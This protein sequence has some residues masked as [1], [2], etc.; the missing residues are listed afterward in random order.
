MLTHRCPVLFAVT[1]A[2]LL[3]VPATPI[4]AEEPSS[5]DLY[6]RTLPACCW[7]EVPA[8]EGNLSRGTGWL[9]DRK[10]SLVVT[11]QHVVGARK[12]ATV[13][14]PAS[15]DGKLIAERNYYEGGAPTV[16][17]RVL[18][19]DAGRDLAVLKLESLPEG[20]AELALAGDDPAPADH[21]HSIGNPGASDA[22]WLYTSGTVR[23]VY[24]RRV[25]AE[26]GKRLECR[27]V[28]TQSPMNEGDSG[29]PV[30]N[31]DGRIV[32]VTSAYRKDARFLSFCIAVSEVRAFLASLP[33]DEANEPR[34]AEDYIARG[35]RFLDRKQN[36]PAIEDFAAGHPPEARPFDHHALAF[37]L[38]VRAGSEPTGT[39]TRTKGSRR[40]GGGSR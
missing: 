10:R 35:L 24:R 19:M 1:L 28:E 4:P 12:T 26:P 23:Q 36:G 11:N 7:I 13:R 34:T 40:K 8:G 31:D 21:V 22:L 38:E 17:A 15:R 29:G 9:A 5:R 39:S 32:G 14:F 27:V 3:A 37:A 18:A 16:A 2:L 20:A 33:G 25:I 6:W 30:V